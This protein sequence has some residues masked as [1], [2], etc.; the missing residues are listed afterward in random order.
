MHNLP[1][2]EAEFDL[3]WSE[4]SIYIIGFEKGLREW[5]KYLKPEGYLVVTE[6]IWIH[7]NPPQEAVEFWKNEY[8]SMQSDP[9]CKALINKCGF[10]LIRDFLLP[11][12]AWWDQY[13]MPLENKVIQLKKDFPNHQHIMELLQ[14]VEM[15]IQIYKDFNKHFGY[16]FYIM[17]KTV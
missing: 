2:S 3:I 7:D 4:G 16:A 1:F 5:G 9:E 8:P 11:K 13:Y 15:E 6:L 10:R 17:K 14:L 12:E